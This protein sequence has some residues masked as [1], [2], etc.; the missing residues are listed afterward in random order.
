M[1]WVKAH[2]DDPPSFHAGIPMALGIRRPFSNTRPHRSPE[3][4]QDGQFLC[5]EGAQPVATCRLALQ[6][7]AGCLQDP[8]DSGGAEHMVGLT[9]GEGAWKSGR[10]PRNAAK[11]KHQVQTELY[12]GWAR[13]ETQ[14]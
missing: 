3:T 7:T 5:G 2:G 9:A 4:R 10:I 14:H 12:S 8:G 1:P 6:V 11:R 13:F